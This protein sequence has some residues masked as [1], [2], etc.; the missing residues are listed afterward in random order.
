MAGAGSF[1]HKYQKKIFFRVSDYVL[2][3]LSF[4]PKN[5]RKKCLIV[6]TLL[7]PKGGGGRVLSGQMP[8]VATNSV[9]A[10]S[11]VYFPPFQLLP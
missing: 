7:I 5:F 3:R 10:R 9:S 6:A 8:L 2:Q 4:S 11:S 1:L